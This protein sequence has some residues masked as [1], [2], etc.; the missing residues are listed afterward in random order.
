MKMKTAVVPFLLILFFGF[1]LPASPEFPQA[2]SRPAW[3]GRAAPSWHQANSSAAFVLRPLAQPKEMPA[4]GLIDLKP[5][6]LSIV[7]GVII[8][9][10]TLALYILFW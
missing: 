7:A 5:C 10:A 8:L 4:P 9:A 2:P 3:R 6:R 1:F